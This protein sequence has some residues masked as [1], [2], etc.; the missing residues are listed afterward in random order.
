M[1]SVVI[2]NPTLH[3]PKRAGVLK[4]DSLTLYPGRANYLSHVEIQKLK[5]HPDFPRLREWGALKLTESENPEEPLD[6]P[7]APEPSP[8]PPADLSGYDVRGKDGE[9]GADDVVAATVDVALLQQWL[10]AEPRVTLKRL[11]QERIEDLQTTPGGDL[12]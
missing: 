2:Y 11:L 4:L 10:A 5:A 6:D 7:D 12:S 9:V 1:Q 3:R 8:E